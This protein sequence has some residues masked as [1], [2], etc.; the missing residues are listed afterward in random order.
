MKN[1]MQLLI[2]PNYSIR[3][4]LLKIDETGAQIA[5]VADENHK[6]LGTVSDGDVRRGLL[7][8]MTLADPVMRC[9]RNNPHTA[10]SGETR[11]Y[12]IAKMRRE[13]LH[14]LPIVDNDNR[15]VGLE[16]LDEYLIPAHRENWVFL[17]AGGMGA[18][19]GDL[20]KQIP[21]PMLRL[22]EKPLLEIIIE[23]FIDQG[24]RKFFISVNYKAEVIESYFGHGER[25]GVKIEYL[26]ENMRMG[27]AGSLSLLPEL[28]VEPLVVAN[29]DLLTN[30]DFAQMIEFHV[31]HGN[32]ATMGV[33]EYEFKI[34]YGVVREEN[35][36]IKSIEEKPL[37]KSLISAGVYVLS[38]EAI[39]CV[40]C[41]TF[42]DMP[43]L[44]EQLIANGSAASI[45][46]VHGYWLDIGHLPDYHKAIADFDTIFK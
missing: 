45:Y 6:L 32:I 39:K 27:T 10:S 36:C 26:R 29:G 19:L 33:S 11:E 35:G 38:P 2:G 22:G 30:I 16:I 31:D 21:K 1:W 18:R 23:R 37:H 17:M 28:P 46:K 7:K 44:F 25:L 34:P 41:K 13:Q 24:F 42:F 14:Q 9:M 15:I 8:G 20:T 5:L 43:K 12:L 4:T 40:P 3:E